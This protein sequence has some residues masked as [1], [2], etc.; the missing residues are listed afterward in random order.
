MAM[1][2]ACRHRRVIQATGR[3]GELGL[4]RQITPLDFSALI[5]EASRPSSSV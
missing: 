4:S 1:S 2:S 3:I 5:S